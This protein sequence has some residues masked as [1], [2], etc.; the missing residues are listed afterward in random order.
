MAILCCQMDGGLVHFIAGI[1]LD[2]HTEEDADNIQLSFSGRN[3]QRCV[4]CS[5]SS[6]AQFGSNRMAQETLQVRER[7]HTLTRCIC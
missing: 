1:H 4:L 3:V 7:E 6:G 2:S 5:I